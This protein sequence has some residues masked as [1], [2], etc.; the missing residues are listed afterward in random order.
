MLRVFGDVR[1][2]NCLKVKLL[3]DWLGRP[4]AWVEVDIMAGET[5]TAEFLAR[6]PAGQIPYIE[7]EDGRGLGQSNAI[8]LHLAQGTSLL[9][10]DAYELA[11]VQEWLFWE[12]YSHEPALAVRRFQKIYMG[13]PD[14]AIDPTL[15]SRGYAALA[16]MEA[17]LAQ[18][19]WLVAG[20]PSVADLALLPY[21]ALAPEGG[22]DL[23]ASPALRAWI[24]RCLAVFPLTASGPEPE[25]RR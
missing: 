16:R 1:S 13:K 12:Q 8:L 22:F 15:L 7:L 11:R 10:Q 4:Y 6:N 25:T 23:R 17:H 5:R 9:P 21:T 19:S 24:D 18:S 2:G 20:A 3:L 14:D